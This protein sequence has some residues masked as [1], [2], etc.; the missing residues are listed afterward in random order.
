MRKKYFQKINKQNGF[1]II[2]TMISV[3]LF[4]III[5]A[6]M[7]ALL[8]A[9][10][11]HTKSQDQRSIMDNLSFIMEDM[12]R[13]IRVGSDYH[14][15][16]DGNVTAVNSHSCTINGKGIS[17]KSS[18]GSQWVYAIYSDGSIQKSLSGGATGSFVILL[19]PSEI[20][21][22]PASSFTIVGAESG[23][24]QQPFVTIRLVGN[25]HS[26]KDNTDTPFNLQTS[27]SQRFEDI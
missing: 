5:M 11:I 24:N 20:I 27:V 14:C 18:G 10:S 15:I 4:L 1:T 26:V 13:N 17:F 8:N 7:G 21:L 23:D 2:E 3:A 16:D 22:D 25:I 6:G 9:S 19:N 12:S